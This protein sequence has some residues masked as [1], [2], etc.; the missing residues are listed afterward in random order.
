MQLSGATTSCDRALV[1]PPQVMNKDKI[2]FDKHGNF[3]F[4][5]DLEVQW[6]KLHRDIQSEYRLEQLGAFLKGTLC[7]SA[8]VSVGYLLLNGFNNWLY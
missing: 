5:A 7:V 6:M 2:Q 3:V 8:V 1:A 4:D